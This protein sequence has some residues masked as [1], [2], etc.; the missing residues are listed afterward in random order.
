MIRVWVVLSRRSREYLSRAASAS[1]NVF[2]FAAETVVTKVQMMMPEEV[3]ALELDVADLVTEGGGDVG[4]ASVEG[5][6]PD[7][8][9]R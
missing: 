3:T 2:R 4:A 7:F 8:V 6:L 1:F 5:Q 9:G